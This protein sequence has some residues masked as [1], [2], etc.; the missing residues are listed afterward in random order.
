MGR[1]VDIPS[2]GGQIFPKK[3]ESSKVSKNFKISKLKKLYKISKLKNFIRFQNF[4]HISK[5]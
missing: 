1:G 5:F 2:V 3:I 4:H